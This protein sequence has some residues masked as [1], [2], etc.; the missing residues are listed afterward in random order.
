MENNDPENLI[1]SCCES[2]YGKTD[3]LSGNSEMTAM[4]KQMSNK[5]SSRTP[6]YIMF[7][8]E[9]KCVGPDGTIEDKGSEVAGRLS[10]ISGNLL[11]MFLDGRQ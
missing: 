8:E 5:I 1:T 3:V 7:G 6:S 4:S 11:K 2:N 9:G 10:R